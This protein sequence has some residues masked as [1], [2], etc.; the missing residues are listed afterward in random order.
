MRAVVSTTA[1]AATAAVTAASPVV[2]FSVA[3]VI[4]TAGP[5]V[6]SS[7]RLVSRGRL[8]LSQAITH[9]TLPWVVV[10]LIAMITRTG[11]SESLA[12]FRGWW[13][14]RWSRAVLRSFATMVTRSG[15]TCRLPTLLEV[16]EHP[17]IM[18]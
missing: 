16:I 1:F 15:T 6:V 11:T 9:G 5:L 10:A 18:V 13:W 14:A 2:L 4:T 3:A 17:K 12:V 8:W 7:C